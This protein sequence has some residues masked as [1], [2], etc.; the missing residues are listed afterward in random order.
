MS[1]A[2]A[3]TTAE[4]TAAV[5]TITIVTTR[6]E[7]RKIAFEGTEW[8]DLKKILERGGK[9]VEGNSFQ[10]YN[11]NNMKCVESINRTT[12]EHPKAA[13]PDGNFNLFLMP[14]KSKSG[15][16]T[17]S[18]AE[19]NAQIKAH[20]ERDGEKA[21]EFFSHEGKNYTQVSSAIL[22][23]KL[24]QYSPGTKKEAATAKAE[25]TA[26]VADI[27][28][29]VKSS[30]EA[31]L[32]EELQGLSDSEKLDVVIKLLIDMRNNPSAST[33]SAPA[34]TEPVET[35]EEKQARLQKEEEDKKLDAEMEEMMGG[36]DD[37]KRY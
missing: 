5:R 6:G 31:N 24:E 4:T 16:G 8:S 20:I 11:L 14:Y 3:K 36:F 30:K 2:Q 34:V 1:E 28:A 29:S 21:K 12:L 33:V 35:E 22:E 37:V 13:I 17:L 10:A 19:I 7:K 32:F 26:N 27:V 15:A 25:A 18:R 23:E 9:D